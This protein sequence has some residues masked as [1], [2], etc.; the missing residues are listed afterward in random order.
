MFVQVVALVAILGLVELSLRRRVRPV[1]RYWLWSLVILKL[2]LPVTL[3]TPA[4]VAYWVVS[5]SPPAANTVVPPAGARPL[6]PP[7]VNA[8]E[9]DPAPLVEPAEPQFVAEL[10]RRPARQEMRRS[11]VPNDEAPAPVVVS[12]LLPSI[13]PRGWF[14]VGWCS[15]CLMLGVIVLR[16]T[17]RAFAS[18]CGGQRRRPGTWC[19]R[20]MSRASCWT[21]R[22]AEFV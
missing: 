5:E 14:F 20:L 22:P 13:T 15:G 3:R 17:A 8:A 18:L 21:S 12:E 10:P 6:P 9:L 19:R 7:L 11:P 16:R 4:S 2:L 1:V